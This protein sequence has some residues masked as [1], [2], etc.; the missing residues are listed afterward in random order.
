MRALLYVK[1][2]CK[3]CEELRKSLEDA[4]VAYEEIN[5]SERRE[6]IPELLKLTRGK[7]VVPVLVD[8]AGIHVAPRGGADF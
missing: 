1:N 5:V 2:D 8:A 7:R 4:G 3:L 6:K